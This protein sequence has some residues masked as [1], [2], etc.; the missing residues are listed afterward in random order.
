[1]E[2]KVN[3]KV[4]VFGGAGIGLLFGVVMGT[5]VTPTVSI[6]LG[7]LTTILGA[8]L[9]LNDRY[10]NDAKAARIGAFGIAC[11][12]GAYIGIY[13]RSHNLLAPS[14][15]ELKAQYVSAGYTE[16]QALQLLTLK[17][18]GMRLDSTY[19]GDETSAKS[20]FSFSEQA[21]NIANQHNSLLFSS[22]IS[23]NGCDELSYTDSSLELDEIVNNFELT[24]GV[25]ATVSESI[26]TEFE[27][28][29][30]K[31]MLLAIRYSVCAQQQDLPC[32]GNLQ[33]TD[34]LTFTQVK[35]V[36]GAPWSHIFARFDEGGLS[37]N[38][39]LRGVKL[40]HQILCSG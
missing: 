34:L 35:S 11:V 33:L 9:G 36:L 38:S 37:E 6:L 22:S 19:A 10:F 18:F 7:T 27:E 31:K 12:I 26:V 3:L 30:Q 28:S 16:Q 5:S 25:W 8:I 40:V 13:V 39:K 32:I 21:A 2:N 29:E 4:A 20:E 15:V 24:G 1:M 17:E 14:L 23:V